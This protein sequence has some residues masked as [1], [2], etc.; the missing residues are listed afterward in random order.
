MKSRSSTKAGNGC[1]GPCRN[2][3]HSLWPATCTSST[4]WI[5]SLASQIRRKEL[6]V[7]VLSEPNELVNREKSEWLKQMEPILKTLNDGVIVADESGQILFVN[8]V[9]EEMTKTLRSEIIG[10]DAQHMDLGVEDRTRLQ[11]FREES[12]K[13]GRGREAFLLPTKD[14]KRL[15]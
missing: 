4:F 2:K 6:Y 15:P 11:A 9:F 1:Y 3:E 5:A 13:K 7:R 12:Y 8:S 14:G 10:R